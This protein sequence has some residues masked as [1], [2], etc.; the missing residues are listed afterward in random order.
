MRD[1]ERDTVG[2]RQTMQT[3]VRLAD[4]CTL[5]VGGPA[6]WFAEARSED[7]L[8]NALSWADERSVVV[9]VLGGGSNVV[10]SDRGFDGLVV[11][12]SIGDVD[13]HDAGDRVQ[14]SVGAG[15]P[16]DPFVAETVKANC[17]GLECL[18]GIPGLVG[19]TPVQNVGAYGLEVSATI[20]SVRAIDRAD[21]AIRTLPNNDCAFGYR[22]SRFKHADAGRFIVTRVEYL[23]RPG[24]APTISYADVIKYF[25][26][27]GEVPTLSS[28]RD[29]ILQIRRRKGMVIEPGNPANQ[30]VGSFFV[31][32]VI[33]ADHFAR[34]RAA[35][36][37]GAEGVPHYPAG[38]DQIKVP[39]AWLVEQ[40]GFRK[41][42]TRGPAGISPFQAQGII[43]RGGAA[44][45]DIV[46]LALEVKVAVWNTFR[47]V[48]MPEPVF[49][50]FG[51]DPD[52]KRL[53][54]AAV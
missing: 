17:A 37:S 38:P 3:D 27:S 46:R 23:L 49:V 45:D 47:I 22:T 51:N 16:W 48:L 34:V 13:Q 30:S 5:G 8:L 53:I 6:R 18:S 20:T 52:V 14:F 1:P 19:G 40:A 2:R 4:W 31:N 54:A 33:S 35:A 50:G 26:A 32:P 25:D 43:N 10:I 41:G 42:E 7:D 15:E 11:K 21:R 12:I 9:Y 24:A 28:T 29:A 36:V 39:A 44:A